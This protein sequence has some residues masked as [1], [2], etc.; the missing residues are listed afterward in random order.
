MK[1]H[2]TLKGA[3]LT[4]AAASSICPAFAAD[5]RPSFLPERA[6]VLH[7][8][9]Q[10]ADSA[11][12][13]VFYSRDAL[14]FNDP[15][16]P[17]F[18]LLD[19]EGK[20]A[21]GI[22]GSLYAVGRYDFKGAIDN[23]DFITYDIPVPS[24]PGLR[25]RFGASARNSSIFAK[26]VGKTTRFGLF[27]V[28]FQANF[29]GDE[30]KYGFKLKQAYA[31]LGHLTAGLTNSTFIDGATQAPTIDP[32]GACGQVTE[33]NML[34]RY[35]TSSHHGVSGAISIEVPAISITNGTTAEGASTKSIAQRVPDIPVYLQ[36]AWGSASHVRAAAIFRDISY[37]D[38]LSGAN[39]LQPGWG[40]KLSAIAQ[41]GPYLK[42]F[43]HVSYGKGISS[44]VNDLSG[45]G[46]DLVP[47]AE[48]PGRLKAAPSLTWTVGTYINVTPRLFFTASL[49][50]AQL[51]DCADLGGDTYRY[52]MYAAANAF[53]NVDDN[54]R[55]GAEYLHGSRHDYSGSANSA[56]RLNVLLQYSF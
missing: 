49:S 33:K 29:S 51:F 55:I 23:P 56:N 41:A 46:F 14:D 13:G 1:I 8:D 52:A 50:R 20:V 38:L 11:V 10:N 34:F 21:F 25:Q 9:V 17:R 26:I 6:V 22:G 4:I 16:A 54:F 27:T 18:L 30:G 7:G 3:V 31:T 2:H 12:I 39:R 36:Y 42:P 45:N 48:R 43:G 28:Y 5:E 44:Y 19:R 53:Y 40:V 35:T 32:Q 15:D 24:D 37:R 47:D